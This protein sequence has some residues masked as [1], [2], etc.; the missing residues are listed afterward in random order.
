MRAWGRVNPLGKSITA[1]ALEIRN[2]IAPGLQI[3]IR[4]PQVGP[5][6]A[7]RARGAVQS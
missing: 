5:D 6:A 7:A 4:N 3:Q 2:P 1:R